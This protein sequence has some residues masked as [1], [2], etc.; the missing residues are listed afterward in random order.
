[1]IGAA[2]NRL[3]RENT[4][5]ALLYLDLDDFKEVNDRLGHEAGDYLLGETANRLRACTREGD[6]PARLGGDEFAILLEGA[7][8]REVQAIAARVVRR[9]AEATRIGAAV[10]TTST[11]VGAVIAAPGDTPEVL[12]RRADAA[13]YAA[14]RAG[15]GQFLLALD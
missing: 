15:K 10:V 8:A 7:G 13:L 3:H 11:S 1:M 14:K 2:L 4:P 5:V 6:T 12:L 9:L